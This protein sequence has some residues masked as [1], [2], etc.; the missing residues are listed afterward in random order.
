MTYEIVT[1]L[2]IDGTELPILKR[3]ND[4]GTTSWI[5]MV[6]DNPDYQRYLNPD[7]EEGGTL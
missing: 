1:N 4:D 2:D 6:E 5:P 3:T 7:A